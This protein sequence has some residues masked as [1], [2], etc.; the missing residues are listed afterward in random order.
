M[1]SFETSTESGRSKERIRRAGMTTLSAG[2]ARAIGLLASLITV[3]LTFR[4][5]GPERYGLWMVLIS[6]ISVMSFADLGIGLGLINAISEA[7]GKDDHALA[8][9][10]VTSAFGMLLGISVI[11]TAAGA[12]AY[13]FM[14]WMRLF[15][16]KS[17]AVA[18]EGARALVVLYAWFV[19]NIPLD[20][21]TRV[22]TGLQKGYF[23]QIVSALGSLATL[24]A[25]LAVIRLHGSLAWLVFGATVGSIVST[26]VNA[27]ILFYRDP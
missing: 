14:P 20:I 6:L 7:H 5:L 23:P 25:L 2:G 9:E 11:L 21:A 24:V 8:K 12:I 17:P 19:L 1:R 16:V 3:P 27:W 13:P 26:V 15:N 10:Y 4:Y 22:Q 18:A